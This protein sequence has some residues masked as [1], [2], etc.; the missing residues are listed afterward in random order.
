MCPNPVI[1]TTPRLRDGPH[2]TMAM[3][4]RAT[5][6]RLSRLR[7]R[8]PRLV[9]L[10]G[11]AADPRSPRLA[12]WVSPTLCGPSH[13]SRNSQRAAASLGRLRCAPAPQ[14]AFPASGGGHHCGRGRGRTSR[15]R[16]RG[17]R[18]WRS[19]R[20]RRP[21]RYL[22][23]VPRTPSSTEAVDRGRETMAAGPQRTRDTPRRLDASTTIAQNR[24][25]GRG[26]TTL[27]SAIV[28]DTPPSR[29]RRQQTTPTMFP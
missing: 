21:R 7:A 11:A 19:R 26:S 20:R 22:Y 5:A 18:P 23:P 8:R 1:W 14:F 12:R 24:A 25:G 10:A 29:G 3:H 15:T 13:S 9:M 2:L 17:R 27:A 16:C 28:A 6:R 4:F